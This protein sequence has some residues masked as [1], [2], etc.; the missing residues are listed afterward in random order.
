LP[1]IDVVL[2]VSS[3][4][5]R[6][7]TAVYDRYSLDPEKRRALTAWSRRVEEITGVEPEARVAEFPGER[8]WARESTRV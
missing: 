4:K 8:R 1:E 2:Q 6:S 7:G 3:T 5:D